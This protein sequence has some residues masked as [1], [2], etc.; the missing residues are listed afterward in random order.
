[1]NKSIKYWLFLVV[2]SLAFISCGNDICE[3]QYVD[4]VV[5][6]D[7]TVTIGNGGVAY[8]VVNGKLKKGDTLNVVFSQVGQFEV[9]S[10]IVL[11]LDGEEVCV[12]NE[13]PITFT[14][15]MEQTGVH[16]LTIKQAFKHADGSV[17]IVSSVATDIAIVVE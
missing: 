8:H 13:F 9:N 16:K 15:R 10:A 3:K 1:M 14:Y 4:V 7:G 5:S 6:S 2:A 11:Y 12:L 17:S